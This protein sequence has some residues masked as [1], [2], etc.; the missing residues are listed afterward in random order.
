VIYK[1]NRAFPLE[2]ILLMRFRDRDVT[3]GRNGT[4]REKSCI[5]SVALGFNGRFEVP[6]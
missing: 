6:E 2:N 5:R 3:D 1:W 4:R